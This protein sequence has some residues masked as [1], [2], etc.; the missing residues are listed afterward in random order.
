M[1][2]SVLREN[3]AKRLNIRLPLLICFAMFAAWQMGM[4]Y[5]SGQTMSVDGRTPLPVN[6][7]DITVIIAAGYILSILVMIFVPQKIVWTERITCSVALISALALFFPLPPETLIS[8]LYIQFFCCCFMIG[9]ETAIIVGLFTEKTALLHLTAVY[10]IVMLFVVVLHNGFIDVPFRYFR[11]FAVAAC[12]MQLVFY[13]KLPCKTWMRSLKKSDNFTMPKMLFG[14]TLLWVAMSCFIILFGIAVAETVKPYGVGVFYLSMVMACFFVFLLWKCF[15]IS[16]LSVLPVLAAIGALG[17]IT[18]ISSLFIPSLGIVSCVL[19][20]VASVCLN[21][22]P[23]FGVLL[24][25]QY[26]SR[27]ISPAIIGMAFITVIIHTLLLDAFRDN[28]AALYTAYL[29]ITVFAVIVFLLIRPYLDYIFRGKHLIS[30]ERA[31]E[32]IAEN[33]EQFHLRCAMS[34]EKGDKNKERRTD[35][36]ESVLVVQEETVRPGGRC[37]PD[38]PPPN[39]KGEGSPLDELSDREK[40]IA[41]ELMSGLNYNEI[42]NKLFISYHTVNAHVRSIYRKKDV[43]NVAELIRKIGKLETKG[44]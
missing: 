5:F 7:D 24:A 26:P 36:L 10:G 25:K 38:E 22:N 4:I 13:F 44:Y 12:A 23:L 1:N 9:F 41:Q 6:V 14:G 2:G 35:G 17:F 21:L 34:N 39:P 19:L 37:H 30:E 27:F 33:N 15:D 32:L 28:T 8:V 42:A 40:Q 20:G 18:A 3:E 29:A 31:A 16:P 43:H 11:L